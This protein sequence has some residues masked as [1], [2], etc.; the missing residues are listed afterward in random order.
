[1]YTDGAVTSERTLILL[2][3]GSSD[4]NEADRFAGWRDSPL[5]TDGIREARAAGAMMRTQGLCPD[6]VH[7]S[8]LTRATATASYAL[9]AVDARQPTIHRTWRLNERHYGA[10]QGMHRSTARVMYGEEVVAL[11]RRSFESRPPPIDDADQTRLIDDRYPHLTDWLPPRTESLRDL[12]ERLMPYWRDEICSDLRASRR[13]LVVSHGN[14]LRVLIAALDSVDSGR[15]DRI[16]IP[17][18]IPLVYRLGPDLTPGP[19]A[20]FLDGSPAA[21]RHS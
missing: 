15:L 9:E 2:R 8:L 12:G 1:V 5:S 16:R 19:P 7:T 6:S 21:W 17:T 11:W 10:L 3:H 20:R 14:T 18:G 4:A 13:V